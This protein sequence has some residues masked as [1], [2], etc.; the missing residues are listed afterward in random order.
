MVKCTETG[1]PNTR[2]GKAA[3]DQWNSRFRFF[4]LAFFW[5]I[6]SSL[7]AQAPL[8]LIDSL[9]LAAD[10]FAVD[11]LDQ[12]YVVDSAGLLTKYTPQGRP[13]F[14]YSNVPLGPLTIV[15]VTDP[16]NLLLYYPDYQTIILLDR[17]LAPTAELSL[18]SLGL[19]DVQVMAMA[20]D[21]HIW[22]YDQAAFKLYKISPRGEISLESGDLSLVLAQP[23]RATQLLVRNNFVYLYDPHQ[24]LLQFDI[25]GQYLRTIVIKD[26]ESLQIAGRQLYYLEKP[27][28]LHTYHL[29]SFQTSSRVLPAEV[30]RFHWREKRLYGQG[31]G[32]IYVWE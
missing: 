28:R 21:L 26:A 24:G 11:R 5:P 23:P 8:K 27:D 32:A 29:A 1:R 7:H 6:I 12:L 31:R 18:L 4:L 30:K 13:S 2:T 3:P 9:P 10:F 15:D 20:N 25:F 22:L 19:I 14:N 17:T 16:F